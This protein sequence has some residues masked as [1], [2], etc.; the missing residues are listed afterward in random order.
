M[1]RWHKIEKKIHVS[2]EKMMFLT[3]LKID[4][5]LFFASFLSFFSREKVY[6]LK[7]IICN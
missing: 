5:M 3:S 1:E 2:G 6:I 4:R 7:I